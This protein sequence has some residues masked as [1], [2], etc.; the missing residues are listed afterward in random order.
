MVFENH[1]SGATI[2][3]SER[4]PLRAR[5]LPQEQPA[6]ALSG[7]EVLIEGDLAVSKIGFGQEGIMTSFG[8]VGI[9]ADLAAS[10]IDAQTATKPLAF[11]AASLKPPV[12][13]SPVSIAVSGVLQK[14][15]GPGSSDPGRMSWGLVSLQQL[16]QEAWGVEPYRVI[17]PPWFALRGRE[18]PFYSIEVTMPPVTTRS[19][20]RLMLQ[21]LLMERFQ[22]K[23]HHEVRDF[24]GYNLVI[25]PGGPKLQK[26]DDDAS[27]EPTP[28]FVSGETDKKG[29][30]V[31]AP[32]RG[33]TALRR[34][35]GGV[36]LKFQVYRMADFV[37]SLASYLTQPDGS[38][39]HIVDKTVLTGKYNIELAFDA[40][41]TGGE[42]QVLVAG[43]V[44]VATAADASIGSG[45]PN[46]FQ[47]LE[48]QPGLKLEKVKR[49]PLGVIVI[50]SAEKLPTSN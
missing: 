39:S 1:E 31:M 46:I 29:F 9:L 8:R 33:Q 3:G 30:M 11:D 10:F 6:H 35:D 16:I 15:G 25:A 4:S 7:S 19:E 38:T 26:A 5:H 43:G 41:G 2:D 45:L 40:S 14:H 20:F 13:G 32:G 22:I 17:G 24:P 18:I 44:R 27:E 34:K 49:I 21:N 47:A 37:T 28:L 50:D 12:A 42:Q 36:L 48:R 23:V